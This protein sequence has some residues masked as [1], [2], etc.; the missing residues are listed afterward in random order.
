[1]PVANAILFFSLVYHGKHYLWGLFRRRK[2]ISDEVVPGGEQNGSTCAVPVDEG[3]QQAQHLLN[4]VDEA[5]P[6]SS[7]KITCAMNDSHGENPPLVEST[8]EAQIDE[9]METITGECL[10]TFPGSSLSGTKQPNSPKA[11]SNCSVHHPE[12]VSQPGD[13]FSSSLTKPNV[14]SVAA[15]L[16]EKTG[17]GQSCSGYEPLTAKLFG[18]GVDIAQKPLRAQELIQDVATEG[19][20]VVSEPAEMVTTDSISGNSPAVGVGLNLGTDHQQRYEEGEP[21]QPD[22]VASQACLEL[23]AVTQEQMGSSTRGGNQ[24]HYGSRP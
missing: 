22:V 9:V 15:H 6:A 24:Q 18:F 7:E 1:L 19:T 2:D 11:V 20:L 21:P 23:F 14:S 13:T 16:A 10:T 5:Q 3:G 4:Q 17:H 12:E 8:C